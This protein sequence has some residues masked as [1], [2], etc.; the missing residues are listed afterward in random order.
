MDLKGNFLD[1]Y[2]EVFCKHENL[3]EGIIAQHIEKMKEMDAFLPPSLSFFILSDTTTNIFPFVSKNFV[4]NLGLD[5]EK[6]CSVGVPYWLSHMHPDDLPVWVNILNDLMVY[7]MT[8]IPV[9]KRLRLSYTWNF[10]IRTV[11]GNYV[12]IFENQS[13]LELNFEGRPVIGVGHL[14]IVGNEEP[15]PLR[16]SIK[17]LNDQQEYETLYS[18]NYSQLVLNDGLSNR[19][20]DIIRL[21][22]L[23]KTS[24]QIAEVLHISS[25]TV[26]THRRNI[27]KKLK[28]TSTIELDSY[29]RERQCF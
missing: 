29:I 5:A 10:R 2:D 23:R 28:L 22:V 12:H 15:M 13:P 14:T 18:R 3:K 25:H 6:M 21:L 1:L 24:K 20:L 9:E 27:L 11:K 19:E 4:T 16:S 8:E 26:D 17:Y 7:T